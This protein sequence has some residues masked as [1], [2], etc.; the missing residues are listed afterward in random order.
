MKPS[1][2]LQSG[3]CPFCI[4]RGVVHTLVP[5]EGDYLCPMCQGTRVWPPPVVML[6]LIDLTLHKPSHVHL[7]SACG[8]DMPECTV[9]PADAVTQRA[10][11]VCPD[12]WVL[13]RNVG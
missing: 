6:D 3:L 4:G 13:N 11:R 9:G 10:R 1:E 2:A 5:V 12:C 8:L 7:I